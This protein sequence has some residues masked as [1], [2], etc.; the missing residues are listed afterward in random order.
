MRLLAI[1]SI[2]FLSISTLHAQDESLDSLLLKKLK[3][4][5]LLF[6]EIDTNFIETYDLFTIK[7]SAQNRFNTVGL[8]DRNLNS[9]IRYVPDLGVTLGLGAANSWLALEV[10]TQFGIEQNE[11][12]SAN[13]T[14]IQFRF[15]TSKHYMRMRYQYYLGYRLDF[16]SGNNDIEI[17]NSKIRGDI[18]TLQF[19]IQYLYLINYNKFSIK[20]PFALNERQKRSAGSFVAGSDLLIYSMNADSSIVPYEIEQQRPSTWN[21]FNALH[22]ALISFNFGYMHSFVVK[23]RFFFTSGIIPGIGIKNGDYRQA[24]SETITNYLLLRGTSM[25]SLGYNGDRFAICLQFDV[26]LNY[27]P[28]EPNLTSNIIE[29]RSSLY[30]AYRI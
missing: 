3:L 19:G 18:R 29:G 30:F 23:K 10:N 15:F 14:D 11:I 5:D 2:L 16:N 8:F 13:Y 9:R 1:I 27:L 22:A 24:E 20:A 26:S 17:Q 7:V 6:K 21:D 12:S 25:N 4:K 28:L